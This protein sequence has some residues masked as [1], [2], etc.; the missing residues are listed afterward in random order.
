MCQ[1]CTVKLEMCL[2]LFRNACLGL[3][4][5]NDRAYAEQ[6][7]VSAN[8]PDVVDMSKRTLAERFEPIRVRQAA[9]SKLHTS[10]YSFLTY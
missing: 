9:M 3:G 2:T 6:V 4:D 7:V 5:G 1:Q 10:L 8:N